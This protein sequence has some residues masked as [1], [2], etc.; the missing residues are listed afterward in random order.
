[1]KSPAWLLV[2]LF[3]HFGKPL[4]QSR[5]GGR[6]GVNG[7]YYKFIATQPADDIR[8]TKALPKHIRDGLKRQVT[9]PMTERVVDFLKFVNVEIKE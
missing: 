3:H 6:G 9:L 2:A 7:S 1:L 4:L 8:S 5:S